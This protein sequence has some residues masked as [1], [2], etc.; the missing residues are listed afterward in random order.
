[1]SNLYQY[2][3]KTIDLHDKSIPLIR[4]VA[5]GLIYLGGVCESDFD[6]DKINMGF[7]ADLIQE[8]GFGIPEGESVFD[9][10]AKRKGEKLSR[11]FQVKKLTAH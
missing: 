7:A 1:M 4:R 11:R 2:G 6:T 9:E 8:Q 5:F 10:F 3:N